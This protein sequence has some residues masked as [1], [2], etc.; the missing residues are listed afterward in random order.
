MALDSL[1]EI[2]DFNY[3]LI[4]PPQSN[5]DRLPINIARHLEYGLIFYDDSGLLYV[6]WNRYPQIPL[7]RLYRYF[8]PDYLAM[9]DLSERAVAD[10]GLARLLTAELERARAE[11]RSIRGRACGSACSRSAGTTVPPRGALPRRGGGDRS[12]HAGARCGRAS[13]TP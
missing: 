6:R 2:W 11:S 13:R 7:S 3:L 12:G 5:E 9:T 8:T 4:E 1:L 10:S